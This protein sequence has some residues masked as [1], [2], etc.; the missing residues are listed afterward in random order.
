[1]AVAQYCINQGLAMGIGSMALRFYFADVLGLDGA[2]IGRFRTAG[3]VPW[4]I[5]PVVGMVSDSLPIFGF[6]RTSYIAIAGVCGLAAYLSLGFLPLSAV[7]VV[8][9]LLLVNFSISSPDVMI[10]ATTAELTKE[11]PERAS[12]MQS[13]LWGSLAMGGIIACSTSGVLIEVLGP[14]YV[15]V[16]LSGCSLCILVP[17]ILRWLPEKRV[18]VDERKLDLSLLRAHKPIACL[19]A[20]MS[21]SSLSLSALQVF[22]DNVHVRGAA[23]VLCGCSLAVGIYVSLGKVTP[24]L[25]KTALFIFLRECFQPGL[26]EVMFLWLR[27]YPGGPQF[28]ARVLGW[29]DCFGYLG[30]LAG[31]TLYNKFL[32][33]VS[34]RR[35]F[36]FA[37]M[38]MVF[39]NLF[40][41]V[42]VKRW[43]LVLG[44]PDILFMIGDSA[45]ATVIG[46]FFSMPMFVLAAKVCPD[47]IE[48][49]LFA[50]L[51]ALSNF[52]SS[53]S[54]FFGV[55]LCEFFGIVGD[56]FDRLPEAVITK[57]LCRLLPIPLIFLLVP[58][59]T[60]ADPVETMH[61]CETIP[62][63][64]STTSGMKDETSGK[65]DLESKGTIEYL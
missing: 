9:F 7:A 23:T 44:I 55:S 25:A 46:R 43:N 45:L 33:N 54:D 48:A 32:T 17:S 37:Q 39:I 62:P 21:I 34:Y 35:I 11:V 2:T 60:P 42:L 56:N 36:L 12:D 58:D 64:M 31:V 63:S 15:F 40:D 6:R 57:S 41:I 19:A 30:L 22:I 61:D 5:K 53:V 29:I 10:D 52:G 13:L 18:P 26:G 14:Q 27:D 47:K 51:M 1:M 16:C 49:T 50:M 4:N 24:L 8:P 59:I 20:F 65:E 38:T 3:M 28:S